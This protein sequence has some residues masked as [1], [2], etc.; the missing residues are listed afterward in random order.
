MRA[1]DSGGPV[2]LLE[3][4]LWLEDR[5]VLQIVQAAR[6]GQTT[7]FTNGPFDPGMTGPVLRHDA[8]SRLD[9]LRQVASW[10]PALASYRKVLGALVLGAANAGAYA[11]AV[12]SIRGSTQ[13]QSFLS[14]LADGSVCSSPAIR[15][16]GDLHTA[17]IDTA[18]DYEQLAGRLQ[19][20]AIASGTSVSLVPADWLRPL[21]ASAPERVVALTERMRAEAI[22]HQAL[23]V[24]RED[25]IVLDGQHRL[26]VAVQ[27]GLRRVPVVLLEL[28]SV[29]AWETRTGSMVAPGRIRARALAREPYARGAL[30]LGLPHL[31]LSCRYVLTRLA[32]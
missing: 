25:F 14:P 32:A 11:D 26:E 31:D 8:D 1:I 20:E 29:P 18:S 21:E 28:D 4:D 10:T 7:L 15:D 13:P 19:R 9:D 16:L 30:K 24:D 27:Q 3:A 2:I 17:S 6:S 12:A 23:V 22:W 5:A